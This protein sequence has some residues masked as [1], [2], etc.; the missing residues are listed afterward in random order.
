MGLIEDAGGGPVALDTAPFIYYVEEHA[1]FTKVVEPILQRAEEGRLALVTSTLTLLEVLV[2]PYRAGDGALARRYETI[3][4]DS[5]SL[6][7]VPLDLGQ[8]RNAAR[9]RATHLSLK[10]PDALQLSAALSTRCSAFVTNDRRLPRIP[11]L[12]VLKLSDYA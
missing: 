1:S 5:P 2:A 3:L 9:L 12:K 6:T 10:V 8:L 11:G 7:L 4:S